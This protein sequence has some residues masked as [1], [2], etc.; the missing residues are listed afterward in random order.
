MPAGKSYMSEWTKKSKKVY[1]NLGAGVNLGG[2][3]EKFLKGNNVLNSAHFI[4]L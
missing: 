2:G 4:V 3:S 1:R